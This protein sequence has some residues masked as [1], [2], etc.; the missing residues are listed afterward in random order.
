[1][2]YGLLLAQACTS[3]ATTIIPGTAIG[4]GTTSVSVDPASFLGTLADSG[5][6]IACSDQPGGLRS[7]V[8]TVTDVTNPENLF[9][10][11]SSPPT[12][13]GQSA[14]FQYVTPGHAYVAAIDAY[15]ETPDQL[16]PVC[17]AAGPSSSCQLESDCPRAYGCPGHCK[18]I[19]PGGGLLE[20]ADPAA[21]SLPDGGAKQCVCFYLPTEGNRTMLHKSNDPTQQTVASPRWRT[22]PDQPCGEPTPPVSQ[23]YVNVPIVS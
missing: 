2:A 3:T 23:P 11:P 12:S 8:A 17:G 15:E 21:P 10:L 13:C 19:G 20:C 7:F 18:D 14:Y 22:P 5:V 4:P 6:G 1:L 16:V 9:V